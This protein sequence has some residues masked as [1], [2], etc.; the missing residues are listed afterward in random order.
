MDTYP[1][2][3]FYTIMKTNYDQLK[4]LEDALAQGDQ[5]SGEEKIETEKPHVQTES[6]ESEAGE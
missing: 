3:E 6:F 1:K 4:S 5:P 2:G